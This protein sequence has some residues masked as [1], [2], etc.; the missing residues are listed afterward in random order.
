MKT[1]Q[2][3]VR[4]SS[5]P[6]KA[7][8]SNTV[9]YMVFIERYQN[10]RSCIQPGHRLYFLNLASVN[11]NTLDKFSVSQCKKS[12]KDCPASLCVPSADYVGRFYRTTKGDQHIRRGLPI[13]FSQIVVGTV[14]ATVRCCQRAVMN[15]RRSASR[16]RII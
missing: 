15:P 10:F 8:D 11:V 1:G 3:N 4:N 2:L 12:P 5:S 7:R 13:R 9:Y 14:A 16:P 6:W